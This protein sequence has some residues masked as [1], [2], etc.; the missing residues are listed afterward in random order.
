[1]HNHLRMYVASLVTNIENII[2][3]PAKWMYYHLLDAD[4]GVQCT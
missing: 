3:T 1:M 2:E 4:F